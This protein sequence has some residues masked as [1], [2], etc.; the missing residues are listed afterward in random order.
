MTL[1]ELLMAISVGGVLLGSLAALTVYTGRSLAG[2]VSYVDLDRESR[3]TLDL[4]TS[5]VRQADGVLYSS[6]NQLVITN[7]L[8]GSIISYTYNPN[9][10]TL[11][12]TNGAS[13]TTNLTGC[14]AFNFTYYM[15]VTVSN[16]FSQ[17]A[18]YVATGTNNLRMI[19]ASWQCYRSVMGHRETESV[20]SAKILIRK[21]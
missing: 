10:Q 5:E 9:R 14:E 8:T 6:I 16:S 21:H 20:Q 19:Q 3:H 17:F 15:D 11:I 12:R 7:K 1:V 18:Q 4:L 2:I 13:V